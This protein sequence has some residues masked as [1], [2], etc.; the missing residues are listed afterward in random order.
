[1]LKFPN[2]NKG[3]SSKTSLSPSLGKEMVRLYLGGKA[4][5][6]MLYRHTAWTWD[7]WVWLGNN[8]LHCNCEGNRK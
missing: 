5:S 7:E 4:D 6:G 2:N 1:M 3:E 8:Q